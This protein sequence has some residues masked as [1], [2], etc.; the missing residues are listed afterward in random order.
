VSKQESDIL[1]IKKYL[2]GE[3]GARAMHE[4][5]K[6][7]L[8][9]PFLMDALEGFEGASASQQPAFDDLSQRLQAR[10]QPKVKRMFPYRIVAIA[11]SVLVVVSVGWLWLSQ[12]TGVTPDKQVAAVPVAKPAPAEPIQRGDTSRREDLKLADMPPPPKIKQY[13]RK[14]EAKNQGV[15]EADQVVSSPALAEVAAAPSIADT[16]S[17]DTTPLNEIVVMNY[18]KD[19][20]A[21]TSDEKAFKSS[22]KLKEVPVTS[23]QQSLES[24][25][26]GVNKTP[27][28]SPFAPMSLHKI[29]IN[30]RI[31]DQTDGQPLPGASVRIPGTGY[32]TQTDI[33]GKFSIPV[34]SARRSLEVGFL[35]YKT[36]TIDAKNK[37][38]LK[39]ALAPNSSSLAEVVVVQPTRT[40]DNDRPVINAHPRDGW[41][42]FNKYLKTNAISPD[43]KKGVV[44]LSFTVYPNGSV[45]NITVIKGL[46]DATNE[47]AID[48]VKNGPAWIGSSDRKPEVVKLRVRFDR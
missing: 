34:D 36:Q 19:K 42:K 5:E 14:A 8:D 13:I 35:G 16:A 32:A 45:D 11:A 2:N 10:I 48:L 6:R 47:K 40:D 44:K 3:L 4:L 22:D 37:D 26:A 20:K 29:V 41:S 31:V 39:I 23:P 12:K 17:N 15:V 46:S 33:A 27:A 38:S 21:A 18:T 30:G 24:R 25:V 43:Q 7:A 9:D 28:I 1:L